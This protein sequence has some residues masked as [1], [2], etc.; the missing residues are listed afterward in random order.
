MSAKNIGQ[1]QLMFVTTVNADLPHMKPHARKLSFPGPIT[2]S[3][4]E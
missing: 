2:P 3:A 1:S 4:T